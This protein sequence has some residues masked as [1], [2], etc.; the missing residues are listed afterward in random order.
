MSEI[1]EAQ[2]LSDRGAPSK[3]GADRGRRHFLQCVAA[4]TV[5]QAGFCGCGLHPALAAGGTIA[6]SG[7]GPLV[8]PGKGYLV[9]QIGDGLY[10]VTD[11][12][13][14]TMFMV[15]S[16]GVVACDAPPTLGENYFK[17]IAEVTDKPV[18]HL[19]YSHEHVDHIAGAHLF[20]KDVTIVAHART[21]ELLASRKDPRR[22][23]PT[24]TFDTTYT[25]EQGNQRLELA[26]KGINHSIDNIFIFAPRQGTLMFIDVVYP[27]WMPYKNLGVAIDIPGFVEAH[28]KVLA[29]DFE[30]LVAGHVSRPGNRQD[31]ETQAELVKDLVNAAEQA[32]ASLSFPAFLRQHPPRLAGTTAWDL[33]QDYEQTLV[34]QMHDGLLPKWRDRLAGT[35]TYLRDNCWAMLE[36]FVVQ[37][38]PDISGL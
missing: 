26:Y 27:G 4:A 18:T 21:A 9:Q 3:G 6:A 10:W 15:S 24:V 38:K 14:S 7:T 13:Y 25:L 16:A 20:A 19:V 1:V 37:G 30:T 32:Y 31:V 5:A 12:A 23:A 29:Y 33:H 22:P 36:T 34:S 8:D 28:R 35:E 17:A 2:D 11:G